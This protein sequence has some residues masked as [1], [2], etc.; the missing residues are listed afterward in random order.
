MREIHE[1][2]VKWNIFKETSDSIVYTKV[3]PTNYL[4]IKAEAIIN[5]PCE[6]VYSI[7]DNYATMTE[8]DPNY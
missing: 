4:A 3:T 7:T 2:T 5:A 1:S 8:W 6:Y